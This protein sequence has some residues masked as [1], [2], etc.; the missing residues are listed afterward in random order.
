VLASSSAYG[1]LES[2]I[3]IT[4]SM[5]CASGILRIFS[6]SASPMF[7]RAFVH[8]RAIDHRV[9]PREIDELEDAR[10]TASDSGHTASCTPVLPGVTRIASPGNHVA[11]LLEVERVERNR[12]RCHRIFGP[13]PGPRT[14]RRS[15]G[16]FHTDRGTRASPIRRSARRLRTHPC[17]AHG[18]R[19]PRRRSRPVPSS[20]RGLRARARTRIC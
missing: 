20:G 2:G 12:F 18:H 15:T 3:G 16:E 13:A 17:I 14:C 11:L 19:I 9:G 4:T 7:N 8:R 6:A 5:S 1:R 10:K